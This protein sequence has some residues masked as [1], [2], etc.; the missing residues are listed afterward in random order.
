MVD[1]GIVLI[2]YWLEV[3]PDEQARRL[4]SRIDDPRKIWKLSNMDVESYGRWFDHSRARDD[5]FT[6]TDTKWAPWHIAH[7]D[8]KR[9]GRLNIISHLLSEIPY[10]PLSPNTC[11]PRNSGGL[12]AMILGVTW[13]NASRH[14]SEACL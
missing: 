3:S 2:K 11:V 4:K 10:K 8:N 12:E 13:E 14:A 6:T 5:M 9:R 1:S 7:T